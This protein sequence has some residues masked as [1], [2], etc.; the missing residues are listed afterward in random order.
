MLAVL[1]TTVRVMFAMARER[2]LPPQLSRVH[3][4]FKSPF[5]SIYALVGFSV[6]VGVLLSVWLGSGLTDVYGY[7]GSIGTIAIILVYGLANIGLIR[8]YWGQPDFSVWRAPG[9]ADHR[10]ARCSCIRCTRRPSRASRSLTTSWPTSCWRGSSSASPSTTYLRAKS[11]EKLA[12]LGATMATDEIDF[13]EAHS[14]SLSSGGSPGAPRAGDA[15][16]EVAGKQVF[17]ELSE[18]VDPAHTALLIVDMQR[19]FCCPAAAST[20]SASTCPCTRR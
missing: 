15:M 3:H 8:F 11:P 12:A 14:A 9:R 5:V 20:S 17:T 7:T 4:R 13:A 16:I 19:D 6:I 2:V 10:H 18:I 1:N